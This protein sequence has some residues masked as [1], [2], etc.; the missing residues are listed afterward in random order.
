MIILWGMMG[1]GKSSKGRL[2]ANSLGWEFNDLDQ[3]ISRQED[4]S[5]AEIFAANGEQAFREMEKK[6]LLA[7]LHQRTRPSVL[8]VGGGTPVDAELR[9]AML[10]EGWC[11]YLR[12]NA[13]VLA[14]RL[15]PSRHRRPLIASTANVEELEKQLDKL[16]A[17]REPA[18][19]TAHFRVHALSIKA[20]EL[21]EELRRLIQE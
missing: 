4:M 15:F 7:W 5:V 10:G 14:S 2:I 8:A 17:L 18:Y 9:K 1:A 6:V 3:L 19:D 11:L 12:A 21:A 16:L 20:S 13:P